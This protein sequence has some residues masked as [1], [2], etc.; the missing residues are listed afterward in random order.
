MDAKRDARAR[1]AERI[2]TLSDEQRIVLDAHIATHVT[3]LS[4]WEAAHTVFAYAAMD[5]EVDLEGVLRSAARDG[6]RIALPRIGPDRLRMD[7]HLLHNGVA[8]A[9]RH[10]YGFL[11][12]SA[13]APTVAPDADSL[14]LVP[15]R[16][17]DRA[18]NRI[19]RGRGFYDRF[20]AGLPDGA[21]TVGIAYAVQLVHSVPVHDGDRPVQ[22]VVTDAETCFCRRP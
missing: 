10:A 15:G 2:R 20:I 18:G 8:P 12:P 4:F 1:V 22:I 21:V 14:V 17:F 7:F 16:V 3:R 6:K 5:D 9:E 19:G 13:D 11:Q